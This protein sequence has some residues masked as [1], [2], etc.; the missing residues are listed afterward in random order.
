M[1]MGAD[2]YLNSVWQSGWAKNRE[3]VLDAPDCDA[4]SE[5]V[6]SGGYFRN[7]YNSGD[8][9]W[10]MGLSWHDTVG[11]MLDAEDYLPVERAREV[12]AMIEDR[13]LT[14][15]RLTRHYFDHMADGVEQHPVA[16]WFLQSLGEGTNLKLPMRAPDFN[17]LAVFLRRRRKQLIAILKISITLNEPLL[18]SI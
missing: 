13:P 7:T 1:I 16:G 14:D 11:A 12:L 15:E 6:A 18:C 17:N 2:L 8:V 5:M 9:M 3:R 4:I 10:A